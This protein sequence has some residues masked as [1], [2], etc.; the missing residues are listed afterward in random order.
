M[1]ALSNG[2]LATAGRVIKGSLD[3]I[4][5]NPGLFARVLGTPAFSRRRPDDDSFLA[6]VDLT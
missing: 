3:R 4:A 1:K 6:A 5:K 2:F